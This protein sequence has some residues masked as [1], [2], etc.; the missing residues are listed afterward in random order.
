MAY[1][2]PSDC[3]STISNLAMAVW[4]SMFSIGVGADSIS[5]EKTLSNC[6]KEENDTHRLV[7]YDNLVKGLSLLEANENFARKVMSPVIVATTRESELGLERVRASEKTISS[8]AVPMQLVSAKKDRKKRWVF[9]FDNKQIWKQ[10]EPLYLPKPPSLPAQVMISP[11]VFGSYDLRS[12]FYSKK[13]KVKR[14]K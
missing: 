10:I 1:F 6:A 3:R 13:V 14:I 8:A 9:E 12:E 7:C 2:I 11:G 5:I 4:L